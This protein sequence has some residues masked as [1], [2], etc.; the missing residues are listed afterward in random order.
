MKRSIKKVVALALAMCMFAPII[1]HAAEINVSIDDEPV[2]FAD[3]GPAVV[4]NRTM[5]PVRGVFEALGFR[6]GWHQ[7]TLTATLTRDDF[8]VIITV[9]EEV[10]TANDEEFE[11]DVPAQ[12]IEGRTM[13]PIRA[14][15]ES[16]GYEVGWDGDTNTVLIISAPTPISMPTPTP[17]PTPTPTPTPTP[18]PTPIPTPT[19]TPNSTPSATPAPTSE[20]TI[21]EARVLELVNIE[22][23]R[24]S[25]HP[26]IWDDVVANVA[27][28]HSRDMATN[29]FM[30][31]IGSDG[32]NASDRLHRAGVV[33]LMWAENISTGRR[34][35]EAAMAAWM[36]SPNHRAN[37]LRDDITHLGVG[38]YQRDDTRH[39]F[40]ATQKFIRIVP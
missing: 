40:Y 16:I 31:H 18:A 37:I 21:F 17:A 15:L 7:P 30:S 36:D 3:Q 29:N 11:L 19:P 20:A 26:L 5:V 23:E 2:H 10:F 9:G 6:V 35:A 24:H 22:R 14:V 33:Y 12:I 1:L 39:R 27:R 25:L 8:V 4:D 13:L 34:S 28:A 32:S 38:F